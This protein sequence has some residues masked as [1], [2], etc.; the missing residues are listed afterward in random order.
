MLQQEPDE[1]EEANFPDSESDISDDEDPEY[2]PQYQAGVVGVPVNPAFLDESVSSQD[3]DD[4]SN[5]SSEE[6]TQTK[7]SR[8]NKKGSYCEENPP[9][10]GRTHSHN[11]LRSYPDTP[12]GSTAVL[13]KD[14]WNMFISNIIT[15]DILKCTNVEGRR[16]ATAKGKE[17]RNNKE[18]TATNRISITT[19]RDQ[20]NMTIR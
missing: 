8:L 7:S 2:L 5:E 6:E 18:N 1:D 3:S 12:P 20:S 14:S 4:S 15:E 9:T 16:T 13:P 11:I 10:H 19:S 17:W